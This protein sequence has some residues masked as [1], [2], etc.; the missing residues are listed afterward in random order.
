MVKYPKKCP[1]TLPYSWT[2]QSSFENVIQET[3]KPLNQ[4]KKQL[5]IATGMYT[6]HEMWRFMPWAPRLS[7]SVCYGIRSCS[8]TISRCR[9]ARPC[10]GSG[11]AGS[12][13]CRSRSPCPASCGICF[14]TG[15]WSPSF[16]PQS[17]LSEGFCS[18]NAICPG[19]KHLK[20]LGGPVLSRILQMV[21]PIG[22]SPRWRTAF[23]R[24]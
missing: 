12:T 17:R 21:H 5:L 3:R 22:T 13:A 24:E 6:I 11:S 8:R 23:P 20:H 1:V 4:F 2:I 19:S 10:S 15:A 9:P 7:S 14:L 16:L 18:F